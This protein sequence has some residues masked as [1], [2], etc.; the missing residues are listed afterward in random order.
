MDDSNWGVPDYKETYSAEELQNW[1][2]ANFG[3]KIKIKKLSEDAIVPARAN[4]SDAGWDLY[5]PHD[6][7][8][9][10]QSRALVPTHIAMAIPKGY[11]GLIWDRSGVAVKKVFIASL[12]LLIADIEEKLRCV[13]GIQVSGMCIL[14]KEKG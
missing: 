10:H 1:V 6:F 8:L 7:L 12:A 5:V 13:Y 9:P 14:E 2:M 11:V 4:E 3:P